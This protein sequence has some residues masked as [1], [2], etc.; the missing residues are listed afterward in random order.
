LTTLQILFYK[1][2]TYSSEIEVSL[3]VLFI[4]TSSFFYGVS[5]L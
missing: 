3:A 1:D 5:F 4:V 2:F